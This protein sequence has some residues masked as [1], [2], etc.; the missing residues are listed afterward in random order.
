MVFLAMNEDLQSLSTTLFQRKK[1]LVRGAYYGTCALPSN[2][3]AAPKS[4]S[5]MVPLLSTRMFA[6]LMSVGACE[7]PKKGKEERR[8]LTSVDN[9]VFV[10]IVQALEDLAR[11]M[12]NYGLA[13]ASKFSNERGDG[14]PRNILQENI[15]LT[16]FHGC[17]EIPDNV[18]VVE[19]LHHIDFLCQ[20]LDLKK[21]K[22]KEGK[23]RK[24]KKGKR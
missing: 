24:K 22:K 5:L 21:K 23:R 13:Q 9:V 6:P 20:R 19:V 16:L 1:C 17:S 3:L 8:T 18:F 7:Q 12:P 15:Q 4:A 2:R 10:E 11:V 14:P